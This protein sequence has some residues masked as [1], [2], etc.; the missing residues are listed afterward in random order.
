MKAVRI[1]AYGN[2][3]ML[4]YEETPIP[5]FWENDVLIKVV[6]ASVNPVDFKVREGHLKEMITPQMPLTLGCDVAG[7][8]SA[9]G[10]QITRFKVGDAVYALLD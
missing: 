2:A 10:A 8:V 5:E 9:I 4:I 1:H 6:A 7:I 3:D